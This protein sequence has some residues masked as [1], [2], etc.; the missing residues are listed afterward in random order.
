MHRLLVSFIN[1]AT[2]QLMHALKVKL[3]SASTFRTEARAGTFCAT[4]SR[5][6]VQLIGRLDVTAALRLPTLSR[7]SA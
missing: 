2:K 4:R 3:N 6:Q 7:L 5:N 1:H